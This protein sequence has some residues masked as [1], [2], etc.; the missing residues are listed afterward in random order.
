M[1]QAL[2]DVLERSRLTA[3]NRHVWTETDHEML[4][5]A[6]AVEETLSAVWLLFRWAKG[7]NELLCVTASR[8]EGAVAAGLHLQEVLPPGQTAPLELEWAQV[9]SFRDMETWDVV[10][11]LWLAYRLI[12]WPVRAFST[13]GPES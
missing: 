13:Q 5:S 1:N 12:C 8:E 10:S 9:I 3:V 11:P 4:V 6:A 7:Q 2:C